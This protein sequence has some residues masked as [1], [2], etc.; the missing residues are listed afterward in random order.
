MDPLGV[1]VSSVMS[2][3][4]RADRHPVPVFGDDKK[5]STGPTPPSCRQAYEYSEE[6]QQVTSVHIAL[7]ILSCRTDGRTARPDMGKPLIRIRGRVS[8]VSTLRR[9]NC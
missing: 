3:E 9:C 2:P 7:Q 4:L 5:R 6:R 1:V 8:A